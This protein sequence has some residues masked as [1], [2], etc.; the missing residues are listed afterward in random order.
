MHDD[1][2]PDQSEFPLR[3]GGA[4]VLHATGL[5][6]PRSVTFGGATFTP[7]TDV[8][9]VTVGPGGM[10]FGSLHGAFFF[11]TGDF[12]GNGGHRTLAAALH[13]RIAALPDG[14]ERLARM[15]ELDARARSSRGTP[16]TVAA[17]LACVAAF[18]VATVAPAYYEAGVF[19]GLLV[20][21]GE[22][23]RLVTANFLHASIFH[24]GID[25]LLLAILGGLAE[26]AYG[27]RAFAAI[28]ALTG[29][30][31]MLGCLVADYWRSLGASGLDAGLAAALLWV[32]FRAPASLP[33]GWRIPRR[34]FVGAIALDAV[35]LLFVPNIAHAAHVGGF[36]A[37]ALGAAVLHPG[38]G[39][40]FVRPAVLR[41]WNAA[42]LVLVVAAGVAWVQSVRSPDPERMARRGE[43]IL[44]MPGVSAEYLND[45]AWR[46][47]ISAKPSAN[48]LDVALRMSER[49]VRETARTAPE[50]LDTLAE[51]H[52]LRGDAAKAIAIGEEAAA[53]APNEPYYREQIRRFN[54]ERAADDRPEAPPESRPPTP[55]LRRPPRGPGDGDPDDR[56]PGIRV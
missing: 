39:R 53:L 28:L 12:A 45:E 52:F 9:H 22:L 23:W 36:A 19:S 1:A 26:R 55:D 16:V 13:D 29:A 14:A 44:T 2:S 34:L 27:S 54:G 24:F 46:I 20:R 17:T 11:R 3:G 47:A 40:T 18:L 21:L 6:H 51:L 48:A 49:A 30:G 32:E 43:M 10:R 37:G 4:V 31:T 8:T 56:V 5:G 42:A 25:T 35:L 7:Y 50:V 41:V 38:G 15:R 33:V